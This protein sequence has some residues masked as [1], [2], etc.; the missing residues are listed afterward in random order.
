MDHSASKFLV[1]AITNLEIKR[2]N[3]DESSSWDVARAAGT[4]FA[5]AHRAF[6]MAGQLN[7]LVGK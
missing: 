5:V 7:S 2:T 1:S 3:N 4:L 6:P